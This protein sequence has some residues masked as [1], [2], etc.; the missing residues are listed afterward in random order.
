M[1]KD[2]PVPKQFQQ[3][4]I[5]SGHLALIEDQSWTGMRRWFV[6][7]DAEETHT[8]QDLLLMHSVPKETNK[9]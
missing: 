8:V 4:Y 2:F 9:V 1:V 3:S 7:S 5:K 6:N